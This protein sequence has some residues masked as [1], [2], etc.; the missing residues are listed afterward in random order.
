MPVKDA[1]YV[2]IKLNFKNIVFSAQLIQMFQTKFV[3]LIEIN[4][5]VCLL[6]AHITEF[7]S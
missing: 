2:G 7:L 4:F 1:C 5:F 6:T 3:E